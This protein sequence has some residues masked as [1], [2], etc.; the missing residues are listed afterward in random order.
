VGCAVLADRGYDRDEFRRKLEGNNNI[1]V[2][3]G[4][5]NRKEAIVYDK[6]K[7]RKRSF[8]ERVF[9]KIKENRRLTV[10]YEKSDMNFLG[11][12]LIAS[13]KILLC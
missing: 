4:R 8:I 11:F 1:P 7:Y 6:E 10:R 9:G 2:I 13:L 12:I 3:P 5:K